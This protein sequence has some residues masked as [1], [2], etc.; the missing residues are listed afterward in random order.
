MFTNKIYRIKKEWKLHLLQPQAQVTQAHCLSSI[1]D[2]CTLTALLMAKTFTVLQ[3]PLL[4]C[5][6][7]STYYW[8]LFSWLSP[9][10]QLQTPQL[11]G[12]DENMQVTQSVLWFVLVFLDKLLDQVM[13]L[14]GKS[15]TD[16][17]EPHLY[18]HQTKVHQCLACNRVFEGWI[19]R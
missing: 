14:S 5:H 2:L 7:P 9:P 12:L 3:W 11:L 13:T 16:N 4:P 1:G 19:P 10:L 8:R 17:T 6:R 18:S 15:R